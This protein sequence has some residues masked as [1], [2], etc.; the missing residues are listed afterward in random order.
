M[1]EPASVEE[2]LLAAK[3]RSPPT[4]AA[5]ACPQRRVVLSRDA[6]RSSSP[7]PRVCLVV[8]ARLS[9]CD[10]TTCVVHLRCHSMSLHG[11]CVIVAH[12]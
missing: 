3:I 10:D 6:V 9:M 11:G 7:S 12:A 4:A 5:V 1:A 2:V 8:T